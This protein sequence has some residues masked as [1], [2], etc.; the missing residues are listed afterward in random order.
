M[1][2]LILPLTLVIASTDVYPQKLKS[3]LYELLPAPTVEY[4]VGSVY[5]TK[6]RK[7]L[8]KENL[9]CLTKNIYF[10][11]AH[12]KVARLTIAQVTMNRLETGKWGSQVCAVVLAKKQFSWTQMADQVIQD[13]TRW[14]ASLDAAKTYLA[15][16]RVKGLENVL[17]YHS[18]HIPLRVWAKKMKIVLREGGHIFFSEI[19]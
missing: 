10:E 4:S 3:E 6:S 8:D 15:G 2:K 16:A 17:H 13:H 1:L 12:A 7:S 19:N 11:S 5:L 14:E 9:D 18:E